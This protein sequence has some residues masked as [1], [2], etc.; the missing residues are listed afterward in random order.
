MKKGSEGD[1]MLDLM[2]TMLVLTPFSLFGVFKVFHMIKEKLLIRKGY[3]KVVFRMSNFR[4]NH[5]YIKPEKDNIK[6]GERIY[7]FSNSSGYVYFNGTTPEIE[8]DVNGSQINFLK[9]KKTSTLDAAGLDSLAKRTYN[10]GKRHGS[11]NEKILTLLVFGSLG[12][13]VLTLLLVYSL[14]AG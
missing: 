3:Y 2:P 8:Y 7:P 9:D 12:A 14:V 13:S 4:K 11:R 5:T 10:L 1:K 6:V